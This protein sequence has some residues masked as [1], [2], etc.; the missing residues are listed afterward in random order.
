MNLSSDVDDA[1]I[2]VEKGSKKRKRS[3]N[4]GGKKKEIKKD[5]KNKKAAGLTAQA[6]RD[7]KVLIKYFT[8]R[9]R[10]RNVGGT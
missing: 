5:E 2:V 8:A 7:K 1:N 4:Y 9:N 6:K 3:E 10:A